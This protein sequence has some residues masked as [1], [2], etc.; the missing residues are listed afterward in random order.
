MVEEAPEPA[1]DIS[2]GKAEEKV[3]RRVQCAETMAI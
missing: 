2:P 3:T 1:T